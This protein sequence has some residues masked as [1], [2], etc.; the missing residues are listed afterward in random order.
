MTPLVATST[1][2]RKGNTMSDTAD[3][4]V[5]CDWPK[6]EDGCTTGRCC[7]VVEH[8]W[9]R[10]K[11]DKRRAMLKAVTAVVGDAEMGEKALR[12]MIDA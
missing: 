8:G 9:E 3:R 12:A 10:E 2:A 1:R 5:I 6:R 4:C 11:T 7:L